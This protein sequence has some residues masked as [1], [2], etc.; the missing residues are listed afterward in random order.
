MHRNS[1]S[2]YSAFSLVLLQPNI[3][4]TGQAFCSAHC[5]VVSKLGYPTEL[6]AFLKSCGTSDQL[7]DPDAYSKPMRQKVDGVL[8][9]I[10]DLMEKASTRTTTDAQGK[11]TSFV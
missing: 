3:N 10:A 11:R 9:K 5:A 4:C 6:R 8:N 2:W 1:G 7:V